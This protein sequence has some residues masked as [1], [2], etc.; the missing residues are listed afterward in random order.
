MLEFKLALSESE[1]DRLRL[2]GQKQMEEKGYTRPY[3]TGR[4]A[5][6]AGVVVIDAEKRRAV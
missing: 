4:R 2:E 6:T 1:I 5:V 3:D